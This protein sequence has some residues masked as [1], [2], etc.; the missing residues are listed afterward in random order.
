MTQ[1]DFIVVG[2]GPAGVS[3]AI[4]LVEAGRNVLMLDGGR[5]DWGGAA[6]VDRALG[7]HREALVPDDGLSP[8]L[9]TPSARDAMARFAEANGVFG[10]NFLPVG[11]VAR[12]G[13][14]QVWGGFVAEFDGADIAGWPISAADLEPSYSRVIHRIGVSG[15]AG[16]DAAAA[17][18]LSGPLQN[19][20]PLGAATSLLRSRYEKRRPSPLRLGLARNALLTEARDDRGACDRRGECLW[21]CPISAIYDARADL[22]RLQGQEN[23]R[24]VDDAVVRDVTRSGAHWTAMMRDGRVFSAP[25][26]VLAAG[27]LGSTRL[28]APLLP[29]VEDWRLLNN[30]VIVAPLLVP[31]A[32]R[33]APVQTHTL[34]Q[35]AFFL[36]VNL[37]DGGA[38]YASGAVYEVNGLPPSAFVNQ[39]PFRRRTG[40]DLFR[41]LAPGLVAATLYFSGRFSDNRVR[42]DG[43]QLVV[44]GGVAES[45]KPVQAAAMTLFSRS[46]ARLG[47][48][49]LPGARLATP[50]TDAHFAGTLPMGG[51]GP[52][53]TSVLGELAGQPGLH[54][55]DG[56]V[57][58][59]LPS[60]HSTLTIMANADR[61]ARQLARL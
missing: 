2:S 26:L 41:F 1:P 10:E 25:R 52:T 5:D 11:A 50:G 49:R 14:S 51:A 38:D 29:A 40:E 30:P 12:G 42:F 3:A 8:K 45:L 9:R 24:L 58:P 7:V 36:P 15:S 31:G 46:W 54:I 59:T 57:L 55:V 27:T 32:L 34:A 35:L 44:T 48:F 39:F 13:L 47:A 61:I 22:S 53:G 37:G 56:S 28:V 18:G 23:F 16:D 43:K 19:P 4:A 60:K 21:G 33:R 17:L 20:P 6:L